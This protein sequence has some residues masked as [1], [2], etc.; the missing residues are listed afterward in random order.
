MKVS[1][2]IVTYNHEAYIAQAIE[3]ILMQETDFPI[4]LVIGEDCSTDRTRE[5]CLEYQRKHPEL[6]RLLL[7]E[8]NIGMMP[9]FVQT[10]QAC[11]GKYV[12]LCE[13]DD[14]WTDPLKLQKQVD[15]L[16]ENLNISL[17]GHNCNIYNEK[18]QFTGVHL[19]PQK[20]AKY[21]NQSIID[22]NKILINYPFFTVTAMLRNN[23][24]LKKFSHFNSTFNGDILLYWLSALTGEIFIDY[25]FTAAIRNS[26]SRGAGFIIEKNK[27]E[28]YK[29][30]LFNLEKLS[31][32][33]G[34]NKLRR[35]D[36]NES[37]AIILQKINNHNNFL[38]YLKKLKFFFRKIKQSFQ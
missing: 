32:L 14:Y 36:F 5:I 30:L 4:E 10:L 18:G 1:A 19:N 15:F 31:E 22:I 20:R 13:G 38:N 27:K 21:N 29:V 17:Y 2:L 11:R 26:H 35:K 37:Y 34:F 28:Y 3:G 23:I 16:E 12:A 8:K 7:N 6:I 25:D 33:D 24:D 9:N